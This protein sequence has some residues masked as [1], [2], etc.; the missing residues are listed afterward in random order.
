MNPAEMDRAEI[1]AEMGRVEADFAA[2]VGEG[3]SIGS[4]A[5]Q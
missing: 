4:A 1:V 5:P 2:L 3:W